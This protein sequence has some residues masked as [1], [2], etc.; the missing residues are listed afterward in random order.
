MSDQ[1]N[2]MIRKLEENIANVLLG[3]REVIR[4][5]IVALLAEGH[6]L[7][8]DAPGLGKT[9]LAKAIAHSLNCQF[10]RLQCTPDLLPSDILGSS[11]FLQGRGEFEFRKGPI[12][13]NV[14]LA[15]EINRSTPRTQS[16]LLEAMM[17]RQVT[18]DGQTYPLEPP[19]LVI[20]TQNPFE[21]EGTYPLP[22]NQMDRFI[23]CTEVGYPDH[24]AERAILT[25]HRKGEPVETLASVMSGADLVKLQ[26][27]VRNVALEDS[28]ADYILEIAKAT[29]NHK[30]LSLGVST[31]AVL[32]LYRACQSL[33]M[34]EGRNFVIPDDV[35][36]LVVPVLAHR[37][38]CNAVIR[39]R[40]RHR[41]R[42]ILQQILELTRVPH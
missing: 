24:E 13:S 36:R 25:S 41:A 42:E 10:K 37:V 31:R 32:S 28:I 17:E 15:D 8:E 1:N 26:E 3:K 38:V 16:A 29:R 30:E 39:E 21:F 11:V 4:L 9:S 2:A 14:F 5:C 27:Q 33:A 23:I 22:E 20:A 34:C 12:F 19:F 7:L 35:K 40:Q 18:A 6:I